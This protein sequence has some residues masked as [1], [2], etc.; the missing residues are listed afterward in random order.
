MNNDKSFR[1]A[2]AVYR[3]TELFPEEDIYDSLHQVVVNKIEIQKP[4]FSSVK[5]KKILKKVTEQP[6]HVQV[7][8]VPSVL[9]KS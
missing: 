4:S 3:V 8:H 6:P 7:E 1:L 2:L 5:K 9:E